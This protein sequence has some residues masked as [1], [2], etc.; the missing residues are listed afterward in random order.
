ML[1]EL[2]ARIRCLCVSV[3]MV[4]VRIVGTTM[5][6]RP[7]TMPAAVRFTLRALRSMRVLMVRVMDWLVDMARQEAPEQMDG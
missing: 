1:L 6:Q 4:P 5:D 7:M 3:S 2:L